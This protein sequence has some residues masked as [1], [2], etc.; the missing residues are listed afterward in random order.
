MLIGNV[1]PLK[2]IHNL[3]QT[4]YLQNSGTTTTALF[5]FWVQ[6][7][8]GV[9]GNTMRP[10]WMWMNPRWRHTSF[11]CIYIH[12]TRY[13]QY[14]NGHTYVFDT[15]YPMG[16]IGILCDKTGSREIHDGRLL[17]S[18]ACIP[19]PDKPSTICQRSIASCENTMRP[20]SRCKIQ[21][22]GS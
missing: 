5:I 11:K 21:H 8:N 2:C 14:S 19:H 22:G 3:F 16:L 9:C 6:Q 4:G 15:I 7:V 20:K 13:Q 12:Q 10:K 17:I 1:L 18:N